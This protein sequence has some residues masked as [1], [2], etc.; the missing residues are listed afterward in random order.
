MSIS[1]HHD[2]HVDVTLCQ[3][4]SK[5]Y[6]YIFSNE[7]FS[8]VQIDMLPSVTSKNL[9]NTKSMATTN[10]IPDL[11]CL[12]S[13]DVPKDTSPSSASCDVYR[14]DDDDD[15][16]DVMM[17]MMMIMMMAMMINTSSCIKGFVK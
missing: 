2:I 16:D 11:S 12:F 13:H 8:D 17:M 3:S 7:T 14:D 10:I 5:D 15:D 6:D 4:T 9:V 1:E